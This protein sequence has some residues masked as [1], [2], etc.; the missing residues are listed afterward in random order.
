MAA[1]LETVIDVALA[2]NIRLPCVCEGIISKKK[3]KKIKIKKIK[4]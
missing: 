4:K 3:N 2:N 1:P